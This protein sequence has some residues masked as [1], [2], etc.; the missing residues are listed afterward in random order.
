MR[1]KTKLIMWLIQLLKNLDKIINTAIDKIF[2]EYYEKHKEDI[3]I[4]KIEDFEWKLCSE[5]DDW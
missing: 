3:L 1:W 2:A 4:C 5:G